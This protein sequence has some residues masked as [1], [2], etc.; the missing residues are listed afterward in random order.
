LCALRSACIT[1]AEIAPV[2]VHLYYKFRDSKSHS[3]LFCVTPSLR[4]LRRIHRVEW[5]DLF[6]CSNLMSRRRRLP[7]IQARAFDQQPLRPALRAGTFPSCTLD[8]GR[9][10][11]PLKH[12]IL[13]SLDGLI[14][15]TPWCRALAR[16]P[17]RP[18]VR[19]SRG[20]SAPIECFRNKQRTLQKQT[21]TRSNASA[22]ECFR[23]KRRL[24]RPL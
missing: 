21:R 2:I 20:R 13:A 5:T 8:K 24:A 7:A 6:P 18:A 12:T 3:P 15:A 4:R 10:G 11:G 17:L 1:D 14:P 23:S 19:P 22:L 16:Q 9:C